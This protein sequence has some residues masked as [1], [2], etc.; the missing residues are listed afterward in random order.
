MA[1]DRRMIA[2]L[3]NIRSNPFVDPPNGLR[4]RLDHLSKHYDRQTVIEDINLD[5]QPGECVALLGPNGAGKTTLFKLMLGLV[6]SSNGTVEIDELD[7]ATR[8]FRKVRTNIG[9]LPEN[10]S[11]HDAMT[12]TEVLVFYARLKGVPSSDCAPLLDRVGLTDAASRRV[13]TYSKGMRQRLGLAQALLGC[14]RLLILD[15]PTTGLDPELR[16]QFFDILR[17]FS[18]AGITIIISSHAL[19][20]LEAQADRYAIVHS[21]SLAAYGTLSELQNETGLPVHIRLTLAR[22]QVQ[23]IIRLF[24]E[25]YTATPA[26]AGRIDLDC[27]E[28]QKIQLI[29]EIME[30]GIAI[31]DIDV[32]SSRLD[33]IYAHYV[34]GEDT[35]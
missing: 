27:P 4:V 6:R 5:I 23:K 26:G 1:A 19:T 35:R 18:E 32:S 25:H 30:C 7:P 14:P 2:T 24:G 22:N 20:E 15:E 3:E 9:F 12:G 33:D 34:S 8:A 29:R 10:V 31:Q 11:F 13:R 16:R 28:D 17:S 21:G